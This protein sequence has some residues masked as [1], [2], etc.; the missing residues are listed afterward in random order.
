MATFSNAWNETIP[1]DDSTSGL[2]EAGKIDDLIRQ[3][4][5]DIRE[6]LNKFMPVGMVVK[7][8]SSIVPYGFK[9]C[10]GS[11]L[12]RTTYADLFA[13]IGVTYGNADSSTFKIPDYRGR[14]LRG[15]NNSKASG[16]YDPSASSRTDRG[17]G[18]AGD[19]VGT[20][21]E[22]EN[23]LHSHIYHGIDPLGAIPTQSSTYLLSFTDPMFTDYTGDENRPDNIYFRYII[24]VDD[25]A[26][27]GSYNYTRVWDEAN[28]VGSDYMGRMA[29]EIRKLKRDVQELLD[30]MFPVGK[31]I[32]WPGDSCPEGY[33]ELNGQ[34]VSK[35]TYSPLYDLWGDC[36]GVPV[37]DDNFKIPDCRGLFI[38]AQDEGAGVDSLS[39]SRTGGTGIGST[40]GD[41][42][43]RH[44]H[45]MTGDPVVDFTFQNNTYYGI[46]GTVDGVTIDG[47]DTENS[48]TRTVESHPKNIN[49]MAIVKAVLCN[50]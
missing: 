5:L 41:G 4:K 48:P 49:L 39:S 16:L 32:Y 35:I 9:V 13:V 8:T 3:L 45:T 23:K 50:A 17:D 36:F 29:L 31:V 1:L 19:H 6:R 15:W 26:S 30:N 44:R 34:E 20:K 25:N 11:S 46:L 43:K 37:S 40:Q 47:G 7:W 21:Q 33:L 24:R 10:N 14:F 18:T 27:D 38:R 2:S 28:P 42:I 22:D 12:S